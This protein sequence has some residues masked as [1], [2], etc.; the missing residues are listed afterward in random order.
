MRIRIQAIT[1]AL[2]LLSSI[3]F[4]VCST[5]LAK[6][7][8]YGEELDYKAL[9]VITINSPINDTTL[10]R[11]NVTLSITVTKPSGWLIQWGEARQML[12]SISYQLD[13]EI[14][15]PFMANSY[16][17]SA[18][19]YSIARAL[20]TL[21]IGVHSLKVYADA[22]GWLIEMHSLWQNEVS[23][24]ASSD[25][26]Y[27]T[28]ENDV[29]KVVI[30]AIKNSTTSDIPLNISINVPTSKITYSLDYQENVTIAGNTTLTGLSNGFHNVTV[31]AWDAT[32]N[33]GASETVMFTIAKT[34]PFPT[35][36]VAAAS[37]AIVAVAGVG[38]L[39]FFK[40]RN[41]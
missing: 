18:F 21:E 30:M 29:P 8:P 14:Y 38:L 37:A 41:L 34:E 4:M 24:T 13:G 1:L 20:P 15:G 10:F 11:D 23:I 35:V 28:V 33:V 19:N 6:A 26:V 32:G 25:T 3:L 5:N 22:T 39:I 17:E 9:P 2:A 40:K 12:K 7:N 31:Y 16:L 36:P 27:F